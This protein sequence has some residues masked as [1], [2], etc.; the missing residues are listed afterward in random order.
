M[1]WLTNL[2][3]YQIFE[4]FL[5]EK[6]TNFQNFTILKIKHFF[7]F[8]IWKINIIQSKQ[9]LNILSIQI[10]SKEWKTKFDNKTIE[11]LIFRYFNIRNFEISKCQSFYIS[12]LKI[13]TPSHWNR[14]FLF[15]YLFIY[16][17]FRFVISIFRNF[18]LRNIKCIR[19]KERC[20]STN[21]WH[22]Y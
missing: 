16:F 8:T 12:S 6:F 18:K 17:Q 19:S 1:L 11:K 3:T 21:V 2:E 15:I 4:I 20:T 9:L 7:Y 5:F 10:I 22:G 13:L 14:H